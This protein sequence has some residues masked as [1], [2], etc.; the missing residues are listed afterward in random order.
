VSVV[1]VSLLEPAQ[2]A[3]QE[4][5]SATV[6]EFSLALRGSA[7]PNCRSALAPASLAPPSLSRSASKRSS[8]VRLTQ[9]VLNTLAHGLLARERN[10]EHNMNSR[11]QRSLKEPNL[12]YRSQGQEPVF[13]TVVPVRFGSKARPNPFI[14]GTA[15]GGA[16]LRASPLPAAPLSA[17]HVER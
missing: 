14:E 2:R 4:V 9:A 10:V 1:V 3:T 13:R 8:K 11:L 15:N 12:K 17:P 5:A 7:E 6:A 16:R